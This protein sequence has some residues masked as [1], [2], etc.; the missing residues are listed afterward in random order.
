MVRMQGK[1]A[2]SQRGLCP[3]RDI[4]NTLSKPLC[5]TKHEHCSVKIQPGKLQAIAIKEFPFTRYSP[6]SCTYQCTA[7]MVYSCLP[8]PHMHFAGLVLTVVQTGSTEHRVH[9]RQSTTSLP[10]ECHPYGS[11][12]QPCFFK[13]A[14]LV[15]RQSQSTSTSSATPHPGLHSLLHPSRS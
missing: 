14:F 7:I 15:G 13:T 11:H 3:S 4:A 5:R 6:A 10:A 12:P 9:C 8:Q 1:R 2:A